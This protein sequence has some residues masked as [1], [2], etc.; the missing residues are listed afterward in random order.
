MIARSTWLLAL[1]GLLV[2]AT[3]EPLAARQNTGPGQQQDTVQLVLEREVFTYPTFQRRNPFQPLTGRD[4]GPR[5][6][7]LILLGVIRTDDPSASV[8][9]LGLRGGGED[10]RSYRVRVGEQLGNSRILEIRQQEVLVAVEEFG[11]T[12]NRTLR[13]TRTEPQA[14]PAPPDTTT[15]GSGDPDDPDDS[16]DTDVEP[17]PGGDLDF[18][19]DAGDYANGGSS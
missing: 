10:S 12:D 13:L 3:A 11:V 16:D 15:A 8:A 6:E 19:E 18:G 9:L 14:D 4:D 5:F 7:D 17:P 2:L 1:S